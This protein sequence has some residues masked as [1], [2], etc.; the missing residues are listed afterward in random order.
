MEA[1]TAFMAFGASTLHFRSEQYKNSIW[2]KNKQKMGNYLK[3]PKI[4]IH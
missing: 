1:N 3:V 4:F 2:K